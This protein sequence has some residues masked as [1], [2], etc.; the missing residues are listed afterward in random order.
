MIEIYTVLLNNI[1]LE[2]MSR[3]VDKKLLH[4]FI[5]HKSNIV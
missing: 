4:L 2:I 5:I 1:A 3:P